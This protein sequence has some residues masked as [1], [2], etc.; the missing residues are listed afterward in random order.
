MQ[1]KSNINNILSNVA[2]QLITG[3]VYGYGIYFLTNK[4]LS[5]STAGF[6]LSAYSLV[7]LLVES[8][9]SNY[10]DNNDKYDAFDAAVL[11][12]IV[13]LRRLGPP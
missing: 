7:S 5:A 3:V 1:N 4:G 12:S 13:S 10:L 9:T 6:C 2:Y 8:L 11:F